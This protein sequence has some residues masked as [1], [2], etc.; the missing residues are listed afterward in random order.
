MFEL[1]SLC[2]LLN[3]EPDNSRSR[4]SFSYL[5]SKLYLDIF[6]LC[7]IGVHG[8]QVVIINKPEIVVTVDMEVDRLNINVP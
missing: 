6:L 5:F 3:D 8:S 7:V 2:S 4:Y 1:D